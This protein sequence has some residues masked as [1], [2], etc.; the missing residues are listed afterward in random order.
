MVWWIYNLSYCNRHSTLA[1]N[2]TFKT[3][4]TTLI[5]Y[6]SDSSMYWVITAQFKNSEHI[7]TISYGL[8][9]FSFFN[10][11]FAKFQPEKKSR[12][13]KIYLDSAA[14]DFTPECEICKS[15]RSYCVSL[16]P[17]IFSPWDCHFKEWIHNFRY[18]YI[19]RRLQ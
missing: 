9:L 12:E 6:I 10:V 3:T 4:H 1:E 16:P 15:M 13:K 2:I 5:I 8:Y 11:S 7:F 19:S 18:S 14:P 17:K